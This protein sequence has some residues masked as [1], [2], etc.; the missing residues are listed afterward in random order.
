MSDLF[1]PFA[2]LLTV[3]NDANIYSVF[4]STLLVFRDT[5]LQSMR[6]G[7]KVCV[8]VP[9]LDLYQ[10]H[11]HIYEKRREVKRRKKRA[12]S[13]KSNFPHKNYSIHVLICT[14]CVLTRCLSNAQLRKGQWEK[15]IGNNNER[16]REYSQCEGKN[17]KIKWTIHFCFVF[18]SIMGRERAKY[19][20]K[21]KMAKR[22][23]G[24]KYDPFVVCRT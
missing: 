6:V 12:L 4:I 8:W 13:V 11:I 2:G 22:N 19:R 16:Q 15:K 14:V 10:K 3:S 20:P 21:V 7:V 9:I 23:T 18:G 24:H 1:F 17:R 5:F